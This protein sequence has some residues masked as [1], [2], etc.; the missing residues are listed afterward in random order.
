MG[1]LDDAH[2]DEELHYSSGLLLGSE[3][4]MLCTREI[5]DVVNALLHGLGENSRREGLKKNPLHITKTPL[6][7]G[8]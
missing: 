7:A 4:E 5:A 6:L 3:S 8:H 1:A 2:L